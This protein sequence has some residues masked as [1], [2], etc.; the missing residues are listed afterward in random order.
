MFSIIFGPAMAIMSRL[1][2]AL[3]LGLVGILFLVPLSGL[4]YYLYGT[5]HSDIQLAENERE[6][7]QQI[8]PGRYF[9]QTV[10]AHRGAS[11]IAISGDAAAKQK[12]ADFT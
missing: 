5:L 12:L 11:Q 9:V 8:L 4:V 6:G 1:R 7:V 3:K 10:Q 2:F